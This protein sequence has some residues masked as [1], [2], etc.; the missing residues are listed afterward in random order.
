MAAALPGCLQNIALGH[1]SDAQQPLVQMV[2]LSNESMQC[3]D[4]SREVHCTS[5]VHGSPAF[6]T[7]TQLCD[8]GSQILPPVHNVGFVTQSGLEHFPVAGS[9]PPV[10]HPARR[11]SSGGTQMGSGLPSPSLWLVQHCWGGA[12]AVQLLGSSSATPL[13]LSSAPLHV[14]GT[15]GWIAGS[16]S[17]QSW[18][19]GIG[20]SLSSNFP[21]VG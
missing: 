4:G 14:S 18:V 19:L 1:S 7:S 16:L 2:P 9:H 3:S 21:H 11:Q 20:L 6:T 10:V 8:F 15:P 12:I 17:L 5:M 13:Q